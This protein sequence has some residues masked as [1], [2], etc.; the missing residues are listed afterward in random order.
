L[1][2]F[3]SG[4]SLVWDWIRLFGIRLCCQA[5]IFSLIRS[6]CGKVE[7]SEI[8]NGDVGRNS[9]Y[10]SYKDRIR[11]GNSDI[12]NYVFSRPIRRHEESFMHKTSNVDVTWMVPPLCSE[13]PGP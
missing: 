5:T 4:V 12:R 7:N 9:V 6:C 1:V 10:V 13:I 3:L 2:G 8:S 11:L